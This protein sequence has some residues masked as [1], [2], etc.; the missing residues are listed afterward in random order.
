MRITNKK[1]KFTK[2]KI[3]AFRFQKFEL[4]EKAKLFH[5]LS[6]RRGRITCNN[7]SDS[8]PL[9][10]FK[11]SLHPLNNRKRVDN[12]LPIHNQLRKRR[13]S[14][15][16]TKNGSNSE[17]ITGFPTQPVQFGVVKAKQSSSSPWGKRMKE[18]KRDLQS[19][20]ENCRIHVRKISELETACPKTLQIDFAPLQNLHCRSEK[21][22]S[23]TK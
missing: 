20:R 9:F 5:I 12:K 15:G 7:S 8:L 4:S 14:Q 17:I 11:P 13:R 22:N 3:K 1:T 2:K 6:N 23:R 18:Q 10:L 21:M 19:L 16:K